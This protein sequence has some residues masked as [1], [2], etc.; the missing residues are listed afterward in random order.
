MEPT[1]LGSRR[2]R[3]RTETIQRMDRVGLESN[4][5]HVTFAENDDCLPIV[6]DAFA[7]YGG[8]LSDAKRRRPRSGAAD[9]SPHRGDRKAS[10]SIEPTSVAER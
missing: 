2:W 8:S 6:R 3:R 9:T 7:L 4:P 5:N 1:A 10:R